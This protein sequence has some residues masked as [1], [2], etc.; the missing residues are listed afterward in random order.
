MTK[1]EA[2]GILG[3]RSFSPD[4][5]TYLKFLPGCTIFVGPNGSGKTTIIEALKYV[6]TGEMPPGS[7]NGAL[8]HDLKVMKQ[9]KII[10]I[11]MKAIII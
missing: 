4:Q 3:I 8:I 1:L 2:I 5:P 10:I 7:K 11:I 6:C 9:L